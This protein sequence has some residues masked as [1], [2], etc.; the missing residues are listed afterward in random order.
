M[1][2]MK[3]PYILTLSYVAI[4]ILLMCSAYVI[5]IRGGSPTWN[6]SYEIERKLLEQEIAATNDQEEIAY[7]VG[8]CGSACRGELKEPTISG[9]FGF[10]ETKVNLFWFEVLIIA[11]IVL[12]PPVIVKRHPNYLIA[13]LIAVS[14]CALSYLNYEVSMR[15]WYQNLRDFDGMFV[16]AFYTFLIPIILFSVVLGMYVYIWRQR[17]PITK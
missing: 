6:Q 16:W 13:T 14:A 9:Y 15:G 1:S 10:Y 2:V 7:L 12:I 4:V 3:N 8:L 17:K 11:L 5:Q